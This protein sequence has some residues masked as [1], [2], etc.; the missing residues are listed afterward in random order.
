MSSRP[1]L[2]VAGEWIGSEHTGEFEVDQSCPC[3]V[4]ALLWPQSLFIPH[5][6]HHQIRE[7]QIGGQTHDTTLMDRWGW[8]ADK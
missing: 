2:R 4:S 1:Q 5:G 3:V 7:R 8:E 6:L